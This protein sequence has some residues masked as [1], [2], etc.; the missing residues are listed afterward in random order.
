MSDRKTG[1]SSSSPDATARPSGGPG[2]PVYETGKG[3]LC[4]DCGQPVAEC[5][6]RSAADTPL[7]SSRSCVLRVE[8][9]GRGGKTV[10]VVAGLPQNA[11]FVTGLASELKRACGTGGTV[12]DGAVEIQGDQ[13]ERLRP[14]LAA[15]GFRVKG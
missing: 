2:R 15:R 3:R 9:K 1:G 5:R 7:P 8:K 6:C 14:L 4:P 12:A 11:T 10:T 13:R